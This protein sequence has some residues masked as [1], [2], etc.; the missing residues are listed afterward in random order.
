MAARPAA[1]RRAVSRGACAEEVLRRKPL[2][3]GHGQ[4]LPWPA[5]EVFLDG[6]RPRVV[7]AGTEHLLGG[8]SL[9]VRRENA[10]FRMAKTAKALGRPVQATAHEATGNWLLIVRPDGTLQ[11]GA[12]ITDTKKARRRLF[13]RKLH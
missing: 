3:S 1:D 6:P 4:V 8:D 5:I 12:A 10:M 9:E 2:P 11:P 13:G 7:I